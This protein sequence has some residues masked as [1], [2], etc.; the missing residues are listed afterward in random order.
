MRSDSSTTLAGSM[1]A[2]GP[3]RSSEPIPTGPPTPLVVFLLEEA[4]DQLVVDL[5]FR[6]ALET[7]ERGCEILA[8]DPEDGS[9]DN[10]AEVKC[11]LCVVGIQAL[12]EMDRW[13]EVLPWVLRYY[14][15]P[16]SLP[17]QLLELCILLYSRVQEPQ[18]MLEVAGGWLREPAN[19]GLRD[20][21]ALVELHLL[22]VLLPLG[23]WAEARELARGC[24]GLSE[25]QRLGALEAIDK[26]RQEEGQ[27]GP[28][29]A[30]RPAQ[31]QQCPPPK[32]KREGSVPHKVLV[33]L[34]WLRRVL[35]SGAG[36][37]LALPFKKALLAALVLGL[38][39]LRFDPGSPSSLPLLHRLAQLFRWLRGAVLSPLYRPLIRD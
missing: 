11:S 26:A 34:L 7:C 19:Q 1:G 32:E 31:E 25:E 38:L 16:E 30:T 13:R 12:A 18:V 3:L 28:E 8:S 17:P 35:A 15:G 22:R 27:P 20:Y 9:R 2:A 23:R 5:D 39:V 24:A 6:A 21:G 37:L 29:E 33:L 10:S 36:H 14:P 4:S